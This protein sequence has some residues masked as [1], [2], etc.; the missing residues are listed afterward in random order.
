MIPLPTTGSGPDLRYRTSVSWPTNWRE[1]LIR[2]DHNF[3]RIVARCATSTIHGTP[4][5]MA[6]LN[7]ASFPTIQTAF[8]GPGVN[9]L[10]V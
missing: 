7:A 6:F 8:K 3:T 4:S 5:P 1:E 9:L 2:V 10:A